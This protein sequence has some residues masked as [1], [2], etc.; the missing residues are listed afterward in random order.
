LSLAASVDS[1]L[2]AYIV[3]LAPAIA[4]QVTGGPRRAHVRPATAMAVGALAGAAAA[5]EPKLAV[6][7]A[8]GAL[9]VALAFAAPVSHLVLLLVVTAIV[10][11]DV[12]SAVAFGHG[13][14][15][16]GLLP[17]DV[18]LLAGLARAG[19][20]LLDAPPRGRTGWMF[21]CVSGFLA[22]AVLEAVRG[23]R[24]GYDPGTTGAELRALA[25]FGAAVIAL[26]I[27]ADPVARERFFRGLLWAGLA[28]GVWGIVQWTVDIPFTAAGDAG[29]RAGVRLTS[30]GRG[31]IQ[32]GL[33]AFPVAIVM[34]AAALLAGEVRSRR[35]RLAL[36]VVIAL[37]AADLVLTYERTFWV[38]TLLALGVLTLRA[39]P[40]QRAQALIAGP[41]L[42]G[43]VVGAMAIVM[44]ADV[45]AARE[46]LL[47]LRDYGSDLS[48]RY[49]LTETTNVREAMGAHP[50]A[51]SGLGATIIWG[52]PY[53]GV[54]PTAE[55]FAHNGYLWLGWKLGLPAAVLMVA[56]LAAAVFGRGPPPVT[57]ADALRSGAQASLLALLLASIAFPA[58]NTL[59]I[60]AV[61]GVLLALCAA[62]WRWAA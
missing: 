4:V 51:G 56:L 2:A 59:G 49:R 38:A 6:G 18:L 11:Y 15:S 34:S 30:A 19:L 3:V 52:R 58:F 16:P 29:V 13:A 7:L 28:L 32:G 27:L 14:G 22:L 45:T 60:T 12:Q 9:L 44:P 23:M 41:A 36:G 31:Q 47:S 46:R 20:V 26:P 1:G 40:R 10:P 55:S 8:G 57:L 53:E 37:N 62:P 21:A 33:F 42:L 48:V 5:V 17:S 43:I 61:M 24:A 54:P 39:A 35:T 25:G 50:I